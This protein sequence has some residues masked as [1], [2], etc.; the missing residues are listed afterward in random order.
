MDNHPITIS[1][2]KEIHHFE[3]SEHPHH[4]GERCKYRV[5]ENGAFVASFEPDGQQYLHICQNAAGL[6]EEILY[7]LADQIEAAIPH[8]DH[9]HFNDTE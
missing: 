1:L 2:D 3:V 9:K 6:D 7:L 4:D 5:F 8:A